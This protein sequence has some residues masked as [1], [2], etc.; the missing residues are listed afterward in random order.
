LV[1]RIVED[2]AK[3]GELWSPIWK[4]WFESPD[5]SKLSLI[6]VIPESAEYWDSGSQVCQMLKFAVAAV[7][8]RALSEGE[9]AHVVN[10]H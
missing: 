4:T 3:I 6:A 1:A 2:R 5:D 8:G 7:T 10:L 9:N